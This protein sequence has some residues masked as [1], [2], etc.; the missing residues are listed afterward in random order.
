MFRYLAASAGALML[1]AIALPSP[2]AA[3]ER[4]GPVIHKQF[5]GT[6]FSAQ[7]RYRRHYVVRRHYGPRY[8]GYRRYGYPYGYGYAAP[9]RYYN[10]GP[11]I[12]VGPY[13]FGFRAW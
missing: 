10:P 5:S 11:S 6:D 3:A 12:S 13:G 2:A 7:R 9:Y 4:Q 1:A 8:Y